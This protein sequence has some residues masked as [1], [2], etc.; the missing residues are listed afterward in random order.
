MSNRPQS[1][2]ASR[3]SPTTR[4]RVGLR[5][6]MVV[7]ISANVALLLLAHESEP[8][9]SFSALLPIVVLAVTTGLILR[10]VLDSWDGGFRLDIRRPL[11][12]YSFLYFLYFVLTA[13]MYLFSSFNDRGNALQITLLILA[14]YLAFCWGIRRS[15]VEWRPVPKRSKLGAAESKSLLGICYF[16]AAMVAIHYG[17]LASQDAYYTHAMYYQQP[18]TL[19]GSLWNVFAGSFECPVLLLLSFLAQVGD[20][21]VS[22]H[23]KKFFW[24]YLVGMLCIY[25]TSSQFRP[26]L[27]IS[28][29]ALFNLSGDGGFLLKFRHILMV[30]ALGTV[31][32]LV[33]VSARVLVATED[34]ANED[35]QIQASAANAVGSLLP[36]LK[37]SRAEIYD[38]VVYRATL[39]VQFLADIVYAIDGG[40][41]HTYGALTAWTIAD[42][43]PRLFWPDKP[44]VIPTQFRIEQYVNLDE[45][46][47]SAGPINYFYT[48]FGWAGVTLG[49]FGFGALLGAWTNT[50]LRSNSIFAWLLLFW[51]WSGFADV[52][53][54]LILDILLAIRQV[55]VVY[56]LYRLIRYVAFG[57]R[58]RQAQTQAL[59]AP[60]LAN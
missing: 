26:A 21:S 11:V 56:L 46:D 2:A 17:W 43:T 14:G 10:N 33:I 13:Y 20:V 4:S 45:L 18:T 40:G 47:N 52:E 55:V 42:L 3:K 41:T 51:T 44:A 49:F 60:K 30:A 9:A 23:A 15:G 34:V 19:T 53:T 57:G 1:L 7:L 59:S 32:L 50:T 24:I 39:P 25:L 16:A 37:E 12:I 36:A 38:L 54:D 27:T 29:F 22:K 58:A 35:N 8:A 31:G 5:L 6:P 28:L 48:E